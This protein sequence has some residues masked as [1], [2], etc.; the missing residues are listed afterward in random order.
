MSYIG[1]AKAPAG[2][3]FCQA[4]SGTDDRQH[5]VLLRRARA[6]LI[7]NLYPYAAGHVMAVLNRHIGAL[8]EVTP[9]ETADLMALV[10]AAIVALG[11]E[12]RA[13]GFNVG[14]NQGRVA[15]AGILDHLHV[16]V[17]PRWNGDNNFMSVVGDARV[18]PESPETTYDRLKGR[19]VG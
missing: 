16:H 10:N 15:G 12:Y 11:D 5:L 2:C 3:V 7:L 18:I 1:A 14:I 13:E 6:F 4:F 9:E 17:V 8:T 19:L